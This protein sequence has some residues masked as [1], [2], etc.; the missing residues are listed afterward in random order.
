[1]SGK[2]LRIGYILGISDDKMKVPKF[3]TIIGSV[4]KE[5]LEVS[6]KVRSYAYLLARIC[7]ESSAF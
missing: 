4:E 1:M 3:M 7:T 6:L 2:R 5:I